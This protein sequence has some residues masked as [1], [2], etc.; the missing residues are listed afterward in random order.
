VYLNS[1]VSAPSTFATIVQSVRADA[2]RGRRVR[3][4]GWVRHANV[5]GEGG[6]LWMR[7]DGPGT[8]LAFDNMLSRPLLGTSDWHEVSVVLDVPANALGITYG[9][10][11]S[12]AGDLTVDDLRLEIAPDAALTDRLTGPIPAGVDS[13]TIAATYARTA[14]APVNLDFE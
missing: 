8:M 6:G 1:L 10:L 4:A 9:V 14:A 2:F 11:L 12:D 5:Q 7:V 13:A 3:W